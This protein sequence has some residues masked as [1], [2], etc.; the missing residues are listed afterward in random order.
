GEHARAVVALSVATEARPEAPYLWYNLACARAR[1][2]SRGSALDA[3]EKA[4]A[5]GLANRE[6]LA[7]DEDLKS[8]R[9]EAR[10]RALVGPPGGNESSP[11]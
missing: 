1:T 5:L 2:G 8:L 9:D 7:S 4:V 3:L 10:F 6:L 11:R